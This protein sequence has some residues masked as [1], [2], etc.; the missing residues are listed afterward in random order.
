MK[1]LIVTDYF[2]PHWTGISKSLYYFVKTK[3]KNIKFD[4]LTTKYKRELK[5]NEKIFQTTIYREPY[6]FSM[7]RVKY[8]TA[9]IFKFI[10][11]IRNYEGV[12]INSPYSNILPIA[13]L[14]KVFNKK[15]FIFHQGDLILPKGLANRVLEMIFNISSLISFSISNKISTYSRDYAM[16]SRIMKSFLNKFTPLL[17]PVIIDKKS[18]NKNNPIY[19]K[20]LNL[21]K[22]KKIIFGFAGRFVEEKGFDILLNIIPK[23]IKK[24]SNIHFVF[25]GDINVPYENFFKKNHNKISLVKSN[26]TMLGLLRE[27]DL[28]NFYHLINFVVIPSRSDCFN[29]VQAE[30]M[31]FGKPSIVSN[32]PGA[33]YLV[34]KT[35]FGNIFKSESDE[36]LKSKIL[37][38]IKEKNIIMKKLKNVTNI[39][40]L[41][42]ISSQISDFFNV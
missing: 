35:G 15:L 12:L 2:Y 9:V 16:H 33:R 21:K 8:S 37:L 26:L 6:I 28:Q 39:L 23:V 34:N 41:K 18:I 17:M 4:V 11:L 30:A 32:I 31:L 38:T 1:I 22:Q 24:N 13:L 5:S 29:L 10:L 7:S 3:I 27:A 40:E 14:T 25:A 19:Q 36:D 20:L 42:K